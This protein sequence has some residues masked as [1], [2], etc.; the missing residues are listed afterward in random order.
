MFVFSNLATSLDG[1]IA[2]RDR[3]HFYLGTPADRREM[4]RLRKRADAILMGASTLRAF[5]APLAVKDSKRQPLNVIV[6]SSLARI[7]PDW[8]FFKRKDI[9]RVLFTGIATPASRLRKFEGR[10]D[11]AFFD[12]K[13]PTV[14]QILRELASLG[15]KK[16]LVE[17]GGGTMWDFVRG[18]HLDEFH[19]TLTPWILGGR[20]AP[21][22]VDGEGF[23]AKAAQAL[24]LVSS[25][26][27]GQE[28]YLTYRRKNSR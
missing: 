19:V 14:P 27:V 21:T 7:S 11:I 15:V 2:S 18:C 22:L 1:K 8:D 12:P 25:K 24:R 17:G 28:L 9:R 5:R 3:E 26:R 6:S 10:A 16:L 20:E 23:P 4:Q 13:K